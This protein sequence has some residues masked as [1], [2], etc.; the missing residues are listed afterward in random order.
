[1]RFDRAVK[2]L[3]R[4]LSQ[5]HEYEIL[6]E[7][8][9]KEEF[10][11]GYIPNWIIDSY[12]IQVMR[13][14]NKLLKEYEGVAL[15]KAVPGEIISNDVGECY[16]ISSDCP[17][18]FYNP[19]EGAREAIISNLKFLHG[20]GEKTEAELKRRGYQTIADLTKH[21]KWRNSAK[22]FLDLLDMNHFKSVQETMWRRI[23][24]SHPFSFRLAGLNRDEDFAIIDIE[25]MGLFSRPI[26]LLG[27]AHPCEG[28]LKVNQYLVR[29]VSEENVALKA[30]T[31]ELE[32]YSAI[33]SFNGRTFDIPFI[34]QRL[35]YY[36]LNK[37]IDKAH[38]DLLHFI[39]RAWRHTVPNCR[40]PTVEECILGLRRE[41]EV[42]GA[43]V[44]EFYRE[45][46][47]TGNVG[48]LVAII[49]H[50]RQDVVSLA[51]LF[52]KL[53]EALVQ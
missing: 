6:E 42:P 39:R 41:N 27:V 21:P 5:K 2:S 44:P 28:R 38:F 50:N 7:D 9:E 32:H 16:L 10:E 47:E 3:E 43:L 51:Q 17:S 37:N 25:T 31:E 13:L 49:N 1:V 26:I 35:N 24:K 20:I 46:L 4:M 53:S 15:E 19:S 36:G 45:Y 12:Y 40:L 48:T 22:E 34:E 30:F 52:S 14:K 33:I 8:E 11:A 18:D 29:E 23:P